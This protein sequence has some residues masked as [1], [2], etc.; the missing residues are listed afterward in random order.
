MTYGEAIDVL[1]HGACVKRPSWDFYLMLEPNSQNIIDV[2]DDGYCGG[3]SLAFSDEDLMA[4]DWE[5]VG[6]VPE[7]YVKPSERKSDAD[8]IAELEAQLKQVMEVLN[9]KS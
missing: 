7:G 4:T 8:R 2:S 1:H 6:S 5:V 9:A 3:K